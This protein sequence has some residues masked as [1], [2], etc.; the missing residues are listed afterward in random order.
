MPSAGYAI[1][2]TTTTVDILG[3]IKANFVDCRSILLQ[4]V[5]SRASFR[6][7]ITGNRSKLGDGS[8]DLDDTLSC[9]IAKLSDL[10]GEKDIPMDSLDKGEC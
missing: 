7:I 9:I 8:K 1:E 4:V 10:S 6:S 5:R 2:H 3:E